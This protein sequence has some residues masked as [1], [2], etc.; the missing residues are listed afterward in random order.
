ME[1]S[2]WPF[3]TGSLLLDERVDQI[4]AGEHFQFIVKFRL[5]LT[6]LLV[7]SAKNLRVIQRENE[8]FLHV[9]DFEVLEFVRS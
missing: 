7:R 8:H 6:R 1:R 5:G 2:T 9:I 4:G 3:R